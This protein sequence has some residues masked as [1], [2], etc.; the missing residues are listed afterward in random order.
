MI[1]SACARVWVIEG[2]DDTASF[3]A[4]ICRM[5]VAL[6][7]RSDARIGPFQ[8]VAGAPVPEFRAELGAGLPPV[9][10]SEL[11]IHRAQR[12]PHASALGRVETSLVGVELISSSGHPVLQAPDR[13]I[14]KT[15]NYPL[16]V[17]VDHSS[18]ARLSLDE[19]LAGRTTPVDE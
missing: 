15:Y 6:A 18:G 7:G 13:P 11:G 4:D 1:Q 14:L 19:V 3:L 9:L 16:R 12:V 5:L 17:V 2:S 10:D 8:R